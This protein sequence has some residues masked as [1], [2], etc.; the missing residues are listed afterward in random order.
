MS[1]ERLEPASSRLIVIWGFEKPT[2]K[3]LFD[4]I[5]LKS[6]F[7]LKLLEGLGPVTVR[8]RK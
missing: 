2:L 1:R 8:T 5:T 6:I 3:E 7:R 4:L